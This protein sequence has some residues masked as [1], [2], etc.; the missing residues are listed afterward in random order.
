M[1]PN[2]LTT[3]DDVLLFVL[4]GNATFTLRSKKT[5]DRFTYRIRR[6][7]GKPHFV[8]VLTG[9]DNE[10][11][12]Q[13]LGTIFDGSRYRHGASSRI[14]TDATSARAFDWFWEAMSRGIMPEQLEIWHEGRCGRCGRTL[15][16]PESLILGL[17]PEC[18]GRSRDPHRIRRER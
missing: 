12:Y 1:Q 4:A 17:G 8:S 3:V 2:R 6:P 13:F 16:V 10:S 5:G 9:S 7:E 14:T 11:H 15:T 18:A